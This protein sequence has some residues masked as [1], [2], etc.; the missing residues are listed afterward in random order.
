MRTMSPDEIAFWK[1]RYE[2]ELGK[3]AAAFAHDPTWRPVVITVDGVSI[4]RENEA[5]LARAERIL[6][7]VAGGN[8]VV[9]AKGGTALIAW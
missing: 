2:K 3:H 1:G 5:D 7:R 6:R 8:R 9:F 4:A